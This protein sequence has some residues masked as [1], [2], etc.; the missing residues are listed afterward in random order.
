MFSEFAKYLLYLAPMFH[1]FMRAVLLATSILP[2]VSGYRHHSVSVAHRVDRN[3]MG[4]QEHGFDSFVQAYVRGYEKGSAEYDRR[5]EVFE[6]RVDEVRRHNENPHRTWDAAINHLV[7]WTDEELEALRGWRATPRERSGGRSAAK[8][9]SSSLLQ[10]SEAYKLPEEVNWELVV[11]SLV[12]AKDQGGCGSCWAIATSTVLEAHAGLVGLNRSFS[13]QELVSCVSNPH[14]CGGSGACSGATMELAMAY[15]LKHGLGTEQER[16]YRARSGTC[17]RGTKPGWFGRKKLIDEELTQTGEDVG[18]HTYHGSDLG[19]SFGMIGWER[20][21]ENDQGAL[22]HALVERGP[23]GVSVAA[24]GWSSYGSGIFDKCERDAVIDHAVVAIGYG[25]AQ[26]GDGRQLKYWNVLN[27]WTDS[28]GEQGTIRL[29]RFDHAKDWC[30]IDSQPEMGT[31]CEG[32]PPQV[33]VCGMCGI[34]YDSV[35]P[36]FSPS[37]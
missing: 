17:W 22:Q 29:K 36:H 19:V 3:L 24:T 32:G 37:R 13:A 16:P 9:G 34:L 11:P 21:S 28:W 30:G 23:V 18:V 26:M 14:G 5:R 1:F 31:G 6:R 35:V 8:G 25:V 33:K 10:K 7:D 27:S 20:L 4:P 2:L 15:T 12:Q